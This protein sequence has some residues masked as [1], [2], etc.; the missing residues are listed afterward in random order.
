[1]NP[2]RNLKVTTRNITPN[3]LRF[4]RTRTTTQAN[5]EQARRVLRATLPKEA[6]AK[7]VGR[8]ASKH[9]KKEY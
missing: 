2:N 8:Q 6:A 3:F 1:M 4:K 7:E 9:A 5:P